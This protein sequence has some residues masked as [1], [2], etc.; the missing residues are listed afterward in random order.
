V[1]SSNENTR[2]EL[3]T[4]LDEKIQVL[5]KFGLPVVLII[6]FTKEFSKMDYQEFVEYVLLAKL[7]M[8][9]M[10]IG[11]DHAFGRNRE[12]HA[13]QL[14]QLGKTHNFEVTVMEPYKVDDEI[15]GSRRI[16]QLLLEG[17]IE[18]ANRLLGRQYSVSGSVEKGESRGAELGFPTANIKTKNH[19]KLIPRK[20]VY[21]VDVKFERK[22]FKGMM[23]IG[24]RPTFNFDPL[25]L[26]VHI[27]NFSGLIY[28]SHLEIYFKRFIREE[29]KFNNSKELKNQILRDEEICR[30]I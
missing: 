10:V 7:K 20:G 12:G 14:K 16:R 18:L 28:G 19:N 21:A 3:L 30:E 24:H 25:T 5:E 1:L 6:P 29:K 15:A 27:F 17:K 4:P 11:Y 13:N 23:N 2:I 9:K 8:K 26:E 22:L